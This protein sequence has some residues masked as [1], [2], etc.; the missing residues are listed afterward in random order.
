[1]ATKYKMLSI[2][3]TDINT[4]SSSLVRDAV[5][6]TNTAWVKLAFFWA[7]T[8]TPV[9]SQADSWAQLNA[10]PVMTALDAQIRDINL[11]ASRIGRPVAI[12]LT[13]YDDYPSWLPSQY[14]SD[15]FGR[16]VEKRIPD[17]TSVNSP[18]GWVLGHLLA[19][20][21]PFGVVTGGPTPSAPYGNPYGA[22]INVVEVANEPNTNCWPQRTPSGGAYITCAASSM[23]QTGDAL[24][25]AY[26]GG[27]AGTLGPGLI[28]TPWSWNGYSPDY[29]TPF[30]EF[31][32][33][34]LNNLG[35]W[36]PS[37]YQ[38]WSYHNYYDVY[39]QGLSR[40]DNM[41][42]LL[43]SKGPYRNGLIWVTE[44]GWDIP[45]TELYQG[46]TGETYQY[47]RIASN[48]NRM[49][50]RNQ[51]Y[52]HAQWLVNNS[53]GESFQT[54]LQVFEGQPP[55]GRIR[56]SYLTWGT[57]AGLTNF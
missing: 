27:L 19:R 42:W 52:N 53:L 14:S 35:G 12:A 6:N 24:A 22:W 28:D 38:G 7:H 31:T 9:G 37:R 36:V 48:Y 18:Y 32:D 33:G 13:I 29:W 3:G 51:V 17:D 16:P 41:A 21:R 26:G 49:E 39:E 5:V 40:Y 54:G 56:P 50:T 23:L 2:T 25:A 1:M 55:T 11:E 34:V 10:S 30:Y 57:R 15:P 47:Q 8:Q 43:N 45:D 44:S 20:Y 46:S 4:Y